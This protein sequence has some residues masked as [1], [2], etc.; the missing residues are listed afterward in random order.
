MITITT[1]PV[2]EPRRR[3]RGFTLVEVMIGATL[4][5]IVLAGVLSTYVML[6]RS[7]ALAYAYNGMSIDARRALEG[8]AQDVRMAS[9]VAWN[10]A[11]SITLTVPDN[12]TA[13]GNQVTYA[14]DAA[15]GSFYRRPG[16]ATSSAGATVL[17][18]NVTSATFSRFDRLDA[19]ATTNAGTKRIELA[20]R[21]QSGGIGSRAAT[22][23]ALSASFI[24]R[25]K[26]SN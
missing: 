13:D 18:R 8:F 25:N 26:P 24:L 12:Y 3:R 14:R 6:G 9:A 21:M 15:T 2:H 10:N 11:N 16:D 19:A 7:G 5:A 20:L 4:G 1:T 23:N 22:D 17:A